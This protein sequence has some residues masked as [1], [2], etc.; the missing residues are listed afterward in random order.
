MRKGSL[1]KDVSKFT[2]GCVEFEVLLEIQFRCWGK[3]KQEDIDLLVIVMGV[4]EAMGASEFSG[5]DKSH[6]E[7]EEDII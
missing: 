6:A 2:G 5:G 1:L 3:I 4:A 7:V